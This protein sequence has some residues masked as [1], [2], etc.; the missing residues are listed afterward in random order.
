ME[1]RSDDNAEALVKRLEQYHKQTV[2]LV[3][4]YSARGIHHSIDASQSSKA[5]SESLFSIFDTIKN[6][7]KTAISSII[8]APIVVEPIVVD[9][10]PEPVVEKNVEV[11]N[12][13]VN[14][15]V[16]DISTVV[17]AVVVQSEPVT[18][19]AVVVESETIVPTPSVNNPVSLLV[20][21][22]APENLTVPE[23]TTIVVNVNESVIEEK[24]E[25]PKDFKL[26]TNS[27]IDALVAKGLFKS[28]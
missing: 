15:P 12:I 9:L 5:V 3:D 24:K 11:D 13:P 18:E 8:S 21:E 23:I 20:V 4:Y 7:F 16:A 22:T 26:V 14:E 2:P 10:I 28:I 1:R 17:E 25:L 27:V 6:K 19:A